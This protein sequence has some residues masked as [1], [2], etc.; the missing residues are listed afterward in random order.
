MGAEA[1]INN[2]NLAFWAIALTNLAAALDATS[3]SV[4][5]PEIS[6]SIGGARV[7]QAQV[8]WAGTSYLLACT[9]VLLLWATLSDVFGRHL[10]LMATLIV[11]AAGSV[12]C[13]VANNFTVLIAGRTVQGLSGSGVLGL[14]TVLI[15]DLA[16]LRECAR[17]Y[18]LISSVWAV[19]NTTGP[20]MGGACAEASQWRWIFWLNLPVVWL[21][22]AG[23]GPFLK[24][25]RPPRSHWGETQGS[26]LLC[27][28]ILVPLCL[29][30][31]GL[32]GV[33]AYEYRGAAH[34]FIPVYIFSNYSTTAVYAGIFV[35]GLVL[36]SLVYYMPEYF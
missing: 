32:I 12:I 1:V 5:L 27:W 26:R 20:I 8:F 13:A 4:A 22:L 18:A 33:V 25:T 28:H 9:A 16:P 7:A 29:G 21:G 35:H 31:A 17:L 3:L 34:P 19:G 11:F 10:V 24:L 2:D 15:T 36:Y 14:T 23:I 30:A 6:A